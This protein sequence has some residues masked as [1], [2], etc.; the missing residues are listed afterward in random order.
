MFKLWGEWL[1]YSCGYESYIGWSRIKASKFSQHDT[2]KTIV[3]EPKLIYD[4]NWLVSFVVYIRTLVINKGHLWQDLC[5][6]Q[7]YLYNF[8]EQEW[9]QKSSNSVL[10]QLSDFILHI[11]C[12]RQSKLLVDRN[13][14]NVYPRVLKR[15]TKQSVGRSNDRLSD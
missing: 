1:D 8:I 13:L 5:K 10:D 11:F 3:I 4:H 6:L 7:S 15:G 2:C 14:H 9:I 12:T